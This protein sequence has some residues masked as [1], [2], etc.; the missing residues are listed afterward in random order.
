[1]DKHILKS[2]SVAE[3]LKMRKKFLKKVMKDEKCSRDTAKTYAIASVNGCKYGSKTLEKLYEELKP[4][5]EQIIK[6]P[7]YKGSNRLCCEI[8]Y[9]TNIEG[10]K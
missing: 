8:N 2:P 5:I 7:D 3:Y 10:K 4:Y 6:L 1:M 9:N